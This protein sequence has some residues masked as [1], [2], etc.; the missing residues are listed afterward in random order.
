VPV[1]TYYHAT[2]ID[3]EA[4][5]FVSLVDRTRRSQ[6]LFA[7]ALAKL[8]CRR[9]I[10]LVFSRTGETQ[11]KKTFCGNIYDLIALRIPAYESLYIFSIIDCMYFEQLYHVSVCTELHIHPLKCVLEKCLDGLQ[12][13]CAM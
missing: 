4:S 7:T 1:T 8:R 12:E 6:Q 13:N 5:F 3:C 9:Q 11:N 10:I 2:R